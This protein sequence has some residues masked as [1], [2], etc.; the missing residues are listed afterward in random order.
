MTEGQGLKKGVSIGE[1]AGGE[2]SAVS[3]RAV[4]LHT[5]GEQRASGLASGLGA[6][7]WAGGGG[8]GGEAR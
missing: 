4:E 1:R 2:S 5:G 7:P 3:S 6:V 8:R